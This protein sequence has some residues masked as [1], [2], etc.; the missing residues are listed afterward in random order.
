MGW[1]SPRNELSNLGLVKKPINLESKGY[2]NLEQPINFCLLYSLL[3][4][5]YLFAYLILH[6]FVIV[7]SW[8]QQGHCGNTQ[9][10]NTDLRAQTQWGLRVPRHIKTT[11]SLLDDMLVTL[12]YN[13]HA[14][15]VHVSKKKKPVTSMSQYNSITTILALFVPI[16]IAIFATCPIIY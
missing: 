14:Y 10:Q 2:G 15:P 4:S 9:T 1:R 7:N 13:Q 5:H 16:V 8:N 3:V 12:S 11:R 6:W